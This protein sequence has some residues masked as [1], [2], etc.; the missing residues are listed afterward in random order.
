MYA[1]S[2]A[3]VNSLTN[4]TKGVDEGNWSTNKQADSSLG[5]SED[6][7]LANQNEC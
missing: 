7:G 6:S 1:H 4:M 2:V 3:R 5:H